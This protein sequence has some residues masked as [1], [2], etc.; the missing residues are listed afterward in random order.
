MCANTGDKEHI[1]VICWNANNYKS[2][3][4][5]LLPSLKQNVLFNK[6]CLC[7]ILLMPPHHGFTTTSRLLQNGP[8]K[9]H[10]NS[11]SAPYPGD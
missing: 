9:T 3:G 2:V 7:N 1:P 8:D 10:K 6:S 5:Y 4:T 11:F